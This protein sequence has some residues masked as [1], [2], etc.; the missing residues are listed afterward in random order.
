MSRTMN[1][2]FYPKRRDSDIDGNV[3]LY[4]RITIN[5]RR[6]E[7]SLRRKV[8][9]ERWSAVGGKLRGTT[10]EVSAMNRFL[11]SVKNRCYQI[12]DELLKEG[13][14][15]SPDRMPSRTSIWEGVKN[16]GC[17]LKSFRSITMK[18]KVWSARITLPVHCNATRPPKTISATTSD[19]PKEKRTFLSIRSTISSLR[20]LSI[21]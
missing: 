15:V 10:K 1:M 5:G 17:S 16:S 20:V 13:E 2:L 14:Q 18:W 19:I 11:D 12:Y 8:D 6:S 4:A 9:E 21:F 7:F 3:T